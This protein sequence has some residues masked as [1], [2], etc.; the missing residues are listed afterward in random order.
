MNNEGKT[1]EQLIKELEELREQTAGL[2]TVENRH[3]QKYDELIAEGELYRSILEA[4][5]N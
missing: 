3:L 4:S 2:E 5:P 1:K